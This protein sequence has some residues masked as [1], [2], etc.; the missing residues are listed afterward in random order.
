[1]VESTSQEK[2]LRI[3]LIGATG[4]IGVEIMD[5]IKQDKRIKEIVVFARRSLESWV[6]ENYAPK[7]TV[8]IKD[9]FDSFDDCKD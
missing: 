4:A 3:A 5:C 8:I 2:G 1:M 6:Q 7:L 9:N